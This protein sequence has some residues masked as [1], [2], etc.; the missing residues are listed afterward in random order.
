MRATSPRPRFSFRRQAIGTVAIHERQWSRVLLSH[1]SDPAPEDG[2]YSH[3][4]RPRD[5]R[6]PRG[7][8]GWAH[9]RRHPPHTA[10][11]G[12]FGFQEIHALT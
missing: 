5:P 4:A 7:V 12:P 3:A 9:S 8:D 6:R 2:A 11:S 1:E 10:A